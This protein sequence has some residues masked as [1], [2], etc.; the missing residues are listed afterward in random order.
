MK[1]ELED[2]TN[3]DANLLMDALDTGI[4]EARESDMDNER[5]CGWALD[6]EQVKMK[7]QNAL[8][9]RQKEAE[10]DYD[11]VKLFKLGLFVF[12]GVCKTKTMQYVCQAEGKWSWECEHCGSECSTYTLLM[13]QSEDLEFFHDKEVIK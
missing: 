2:F 12:C 3:Y 13:C 8:I 5:S 10:D 6:I 7:V 11:S 1:L 9:K 4:R